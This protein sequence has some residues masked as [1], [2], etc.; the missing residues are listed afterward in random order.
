M[1]EGAHH[2]TIIHIIAGC[3]CNEKVVVFL[4]IFQVYERSDPEVFSR[5]GCNEP[6]VFS[7]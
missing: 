2:E 6:V 3:G 1:Q 4:S 5:G 7:R